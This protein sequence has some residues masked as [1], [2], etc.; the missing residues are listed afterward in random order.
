MAAV[1]WVIVA[2]VAGCCCWILCRGGVKVDCGDMGS[3]KAEAIALEVLLD[4]VVLLCNRT[5]YFVACHIN[6]IFP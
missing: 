3:F 2:V 1:G 5:G 6:P 4:D